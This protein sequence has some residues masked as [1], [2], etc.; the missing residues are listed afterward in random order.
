MLIGVDCQMYYFDNAATT[1]PK[2]EQVYQAVDEFSRLWAANPGRSSHRMALAASN[3]VDA[4]REAVSRLFSVAD[5]SRV[6]FAMN[7]TDAINIALY[8]LLQPGDHVVTSAME[9][10]AVIRPLAALQERGVTVTK[11][12]AAPDGSISADSVMAALR[13][14]TRLVALTHASNVTG[15]IMPV[16]EVGARLRGHGAYFMVD[17]AQS[18]GVLPIDVDAMGIDLLAF[19]GHKCLLG[20]QGT[21]GLVVGERV[22]LRPTRQG[23]TGTHSMLEEQPKEMPEAL[24]SGTLNGAG[25]AGLGAGVRFVLDKGLDRIRAEEAMLLERMLEGLSSIE[26]VHLYGPCDPGRQV[27][28]LSVNLPGWEP[29]DLGVA[30][31]VEFDIAVRTGLHCAPGAHRTIGTFPTGT[32]RVSPG[33]FT[34]SED[35][36]HLVGA[37]K[38]LAARRRKSTHLG[39]AMSVY[40][41]Q[42]VNVPARHPGAS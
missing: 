4:T 31:D 21:G 30:L 12:A 11:V 3:I 27:A 37:M 2:P 19:P 20:P 23:G 39:L 32:V 6:V 13:P 16:E 24:E 18:A 17:A 28:V 9:H 34:T 41:G 15:T 38:S 36:D 40:P 33:P 1:Y 8:G 14:D 35:L 42:V 29:T 25:I 7:T 22:A 26:G 10:N 5:P